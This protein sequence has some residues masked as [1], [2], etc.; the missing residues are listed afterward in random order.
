VRFI[1][2]SR[3]Q[4]LGVSAL[5]AVG[6][7][8]A[9][10]TLLWQTAA[11]VV[12][13]IILQLAVLVAVVYFHNGLASSYGVM[14]RELAEAVKGIHKLDADVAK[15]S[16]QV[17]DIVT[18]EVTRDVGK[19]IEELEAQT[20]AGFVQATADEWAMHNLVKLIAITGPFPAPG[21]GWAVTPNTLVELVSMVLS[22]PRDLL[23][24]EC[25][26]G[27][28]TVWFAHCQKTK[29]GRGRVVAL[30]HDPKY[31]EQ[32]RGHIRRLGLDGWAEV[33][34]ARLVEFELE[35]RTVLWYDPQ[36]VADLNRIDV[37]FVDGPPGYTSTEARFPA[38]PVLARQLARDA[39]VVLDDVTR[40][41]ESSIAERWVSA[42]YAGVRLTPDRRTDRAEIFRVTH[43]ATDRLRADADGS[44]VSDL[45]RREVDTT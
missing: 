10:L 11:G 24:V 4:T 39:I 5:V 45:I 29:G 3:Q 22:D 26:S 23:V 28:S 37:L 38:F 9:A 2:V 44:H 27:T 40:G 34:D 8:G 15:S 17:I 1:T 35:G 30:E 41:H 6:L 13:L 42:E 18:R 43:K 20:K 7:I 19:L 32:T 33:R 31:A 14:R 12:F 36:A 25:G 21:G 16:G